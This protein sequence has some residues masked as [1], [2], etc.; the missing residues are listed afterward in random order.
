LRTGQFLASDGGLVGKGIRGRSSA[1][2]IGLKN[3]LKKETVLGDG[4]KGIL[5]VVE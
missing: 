4:K 5:V 1:R 3:V 2:S